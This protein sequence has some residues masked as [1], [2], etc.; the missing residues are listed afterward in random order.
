MSAES[1]PPEEL[2]LEV[3]RWEQAVWSPDATTGTIDLRNEATRAALSA[4]WTV[5]DV[6]GR[7]GVKPADVAR[8]AGASHHLLTE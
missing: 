2:L 3:A 5:D 7:V 8:W 6:A 4:G 1:S